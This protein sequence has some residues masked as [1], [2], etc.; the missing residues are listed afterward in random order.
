MSKIQIQGPF[1]ND[2]LENTHSSNYTTD[3]IL[4]PTYMITPHKGFETVVLPNESLAILAYGKLY[5]KNTSPLDIELDQIALCEAILEKKPGAATTLALKDI[6]IHY[7]NAIS[8]ITPKIAAGWNRWSDNILDLFLDHRIHKVLWGSGNCGKSIIMAVLLYTKWRVRPN[9]RMVVI[10]SRIMKDA[11]AR[12]FGYIKDIHIN[13]PPCSDHKITLVENAHEKGIFCQMHDV[14]ENK[15]VKNDRACIINLPIKV[16]ARTTEIGGNLLGKHPD[17]RLILAFDEAQELLGTMA[18]DKIFV[19]WYTNKRLD[20]YA[21]GNPIPVDYYSPDSHDLL[22]KLGSAQLSLDALKRWEKQAS[23]TNTRTWGDTRV[24]HL[25]MMDSPKDDPDEI[26]Y[27]VTRGDGT[28]DQRLFFLAGKDN[29]ERIAKKISP[30]AASWYS[31]VLGFPFLDISGTIQ[32]SVISNYIIQKTQSYP[33]RWSTPE[34]QLE[35]FMGV[36]PSITGKRD[37]TSIVCARKGLMVDGR[38]GIDLMQGK[39]CKRITAEGDNDFT[40]TIINSM[41]S[42]SQ[43]LKIPLKNIAIDVHGSGEVMR[44]AMSAHIEKGKWA[45]NKLNGQDFFAVNP[46]LAPTDRWMFKTLGNM[47]QS[48]DMCSDISTEYWVAVRCAVI[49]RQI[50]NIP[51]FILRQFYNRYLLKNSNNTKY[52]IETKAQLRKRGVKSPNDGDALCIM[53][54]GLRNRG[55]FAYKFN[56]AN[57]YKE[58]YG[59]QYSLLQKQRKASTRL[60]A[61]SRLLQLGEHLGEHTTKPNARKKYGNCNIDSV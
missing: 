44:Y 10:A 58:V 61:I 38:I 49:S 21:W 5:R 54:D 42:L 57:S 31:Q 20:V 25:S 14:K 16:N 35:W 40:D 39:Y 56:S 24:L 30:N 17:D 28:K 41:F 60:G 26:N 47:M 45:D 1:S 15:W 48:K 27:M 12:V 36:D 8:L 46:T 51:E 23:T 43:T 6:K 37:A 19:N 50:F 59:E 11:S 3:A 34:D 18:D 9:Q 2:D 13:A 33:L 7:K 32:Q 4:T 52:K 53:M 29:V 55:G 22:F